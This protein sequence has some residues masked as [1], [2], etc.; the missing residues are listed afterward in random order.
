VALKHV[1]LSDLYLGWSLL[2]MMVLGTIAFF[3]APNDLIAMAK[4]VG[5]A[6]EVAAFLG[7]WFAVP[8]WLV[9]KIVS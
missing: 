3:Q 4:H 7:A 9:I 6:T 1:S 5:R 2:F 8:M